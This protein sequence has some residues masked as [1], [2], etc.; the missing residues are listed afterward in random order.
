MEKT[1]KHFFKIYFA[2][3]SLAFGFPLILVEIIGV[4]GGLRLIDEFSLVY[5][6]SFILLHLLGGLL[7]GA[8]VVKN[9]PERDHIKSGL[10]TGLL[11]YLLHQFTYVVFYSAGVLGDPYTL[12][13]LV[14]GSTAGAFIFGRLYGR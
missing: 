3:A 11:A 10:V 14:G 5:S 2:G 1:E 4:I 13:G 8:L 7:G 9:M 12:L 6:I